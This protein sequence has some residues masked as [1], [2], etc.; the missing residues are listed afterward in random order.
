MARFAPAPGPA[1]NLAMWGWGPALTTFVSDGILTVFCLCQRDLSAKIAAHG[2]TD[3]AGIVVAP[4]VAG[5]R[6]S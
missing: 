4:I 5:R 1:V 3:L 2:V 6:P